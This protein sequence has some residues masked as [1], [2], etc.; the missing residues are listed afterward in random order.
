MSTQNKLKKLI[1]LAVTILVTA[2]ATTSTPPVSKQIVAP[3]HKFVLAIKSQDKQLTAG[4]IQ[5]LNTP[6]VNIYPN[7]KRGGYILELNK[8]ANTATLLGKPQLFGMLHKET[9][10]TS[11]ITSY[12]LRTFTGKTLISGEIITVGDDHTVI[13]PSLIH[14]SK[15]TPAIITDIA[16]QIQP[17]LE[18]N[19][20]PRKW[21]AIVIRKHDYRHVVIQATA[22]ENVRIGEKFSASNGAL[23][24]AVMFDDTTGL[25]ILRVM[26][27]LLPPVGSRLEL[28][29]SSTNKA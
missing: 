7:Y 9:R 12:K 24:Q 15:L 18:Q 20:Y 16:K 17:I 1:V 6:F 5:F 3:K 10:P 8:K 19:L 13:T 2:C 21:Q 26:D 29:V 28:L 14:S 4:L 11:F 22:K 23:L 25:A 27:G